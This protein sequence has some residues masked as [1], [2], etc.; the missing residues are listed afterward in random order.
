MKKWITLSLC[1]LMSAFAF[2]QSENNEE[3]PFKGYEISGL[4]NVGDLTVFHAGTAVKDG[5]IVTNGGRVLG[6]TAV[7]K[8][9]DEAIKNAYAGVAKISWTDE[10]HRSDIGIKKY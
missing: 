4:D 8:D 1:L 9:L 5:K 6:V 3:Q 2:G 7:G 10:F